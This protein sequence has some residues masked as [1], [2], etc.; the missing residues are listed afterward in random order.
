MNKLTLTNTFPTAHLHGPIYC[1]G[2]VRT[3]YMSGLELF[4]W[5]F[6]FRLPRAHDFTLTVVTG[7]SIYFQFNQLNEMKLGKT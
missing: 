2:N 6:Q 1:R 4:E 3:Q 5:Y 7:E